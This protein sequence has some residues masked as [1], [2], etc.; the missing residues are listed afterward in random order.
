MTWNKPKSRKNSGAAP[1][2]DTRFLRCN[3]CS[4]PGEGYGEYRVGTLMI[5]ETV[6]LDQGTAPSLDIGAVI[7]C[8]NEACGKTYYNQTEQKRMRVCQKPPVFRPAKNFALLG[9]EEANVH[10][11]L[12]ACHGQPTFYMDELKDGKLRH[13]STP[14]S[15]VEAIQPRFNPVPD[16]QPAA[17]EAM[18]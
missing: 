2:I 3:T 18:F 10:R 11:L 7:R 6:R 1:V 4:V 8:P 9:V 15:L 14:E 12:R 17:Q 13:Q 16:Q 5:R